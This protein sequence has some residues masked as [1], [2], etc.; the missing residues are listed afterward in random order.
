MSPQ[1]ITRSSRRFS[2]A[3]S[4]QRK[5]DF[6]ASFAPWADNHHHSDL[7][8]LSVSEIQ[9]TGF[10]FAGIVVNGEALGHT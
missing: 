1:K 4:I 8:S 3:S 5:R 7:G 9:E 10:D 6:A 2:I